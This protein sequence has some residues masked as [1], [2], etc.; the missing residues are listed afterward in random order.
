M[1]IIGFIVLGDRT[2]HGGQ[3]FTVHRIVPLTA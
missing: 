3:A 1:A 2:S